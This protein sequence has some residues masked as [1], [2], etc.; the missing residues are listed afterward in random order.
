[1]A[2]H[3]KIRKIAYFIIACDKIISARENILLNRRSGSFV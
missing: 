3:L 1:M 2:A